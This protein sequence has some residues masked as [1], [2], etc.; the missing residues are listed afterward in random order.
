MLR[1]D[2]I[3]TKMFDFVARVLIGWRVQN[4]C[5]PA[6]HNSCFKVKHFYFCVMVGYLFRPEYN[7]DYYY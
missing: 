3:K 4:I 6:N 7:N 2:Y 5:Q 1:C